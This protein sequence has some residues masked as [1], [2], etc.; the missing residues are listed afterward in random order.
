VDH[1]VEAAELV[2]L[3]GNCSCA[4][5]RSEVS[6]DDSPG[7][8]RRREGIA[9]STLVSPVQYDLMALLDQQPGRHEAEAIR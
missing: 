7:A 8:G 5:D 1:G 9:T 6:A 4:G 3:A 2:D